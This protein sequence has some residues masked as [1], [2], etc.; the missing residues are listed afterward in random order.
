MAGAQVSV[1][2]SDDPRTAV[3]TATTDEAG[4]WLWVADR[5]GTWTFQVRQAGHGSVTRLEVSPQEAAEPHDS[6][7][8]TTAA[9]TASAA[10]LPRWIALGSV[11]WGAIGT[12]LFFARSAERPQP[13]RSQNGSVS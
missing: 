8:E 11:I 6:A 9:R 4:R 1:F 12:A 2:H 3:L 5:P 13:P 7:F 10:A